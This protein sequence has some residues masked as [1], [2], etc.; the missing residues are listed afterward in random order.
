MATEL[1]MEIG[2]RLRERRRQ[3]GM[4]Q[5][6]VAALLGISV[7]YYGEIERGK[8]QLSVSR[9]LNIYEKLDLDP[10]Y[11]LTGE[12]ITGKAL[13]EVM[14]DCPKEKEPILEQILGCL[15]LLYK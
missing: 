2:D 4:T 11:L 14:K 12:Q 15:A 10:T 3:M 8:R 1:F 13:Y 9:I 7:T 5:E 6:D